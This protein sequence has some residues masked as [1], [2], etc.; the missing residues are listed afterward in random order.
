MEITDL[1]KQVYKV[2]RLQ[3]EYYAKRIQAKLIASKVAE[4]E[5]DKMLDQIAGQLM[6][7]F[8]VQHDPAEA[9]Y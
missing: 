1:I 5:L 3:K 6:I 9:I 4:A 7:D 8:E 2:R